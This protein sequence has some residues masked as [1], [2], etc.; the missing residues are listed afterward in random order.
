MSQ[1]VVR[2][3]KSALSHIWRWIDFIQSFALFSAVTVV[4]ATFVYLLVSNS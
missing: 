3:Q 4:L 1:K 2:Q